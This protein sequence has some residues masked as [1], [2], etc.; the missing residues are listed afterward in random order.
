MAQIKCI[1]ITDLLVNPENYRFDPVASQKQAID[2]MINDQRENIFNIAKH[3]V[4]N[5]QNPNDMI[6]VAV[7]NHDK[8]KYIVLEGN[9]RVVA[10][11]ALINPDII[12]NKDNATLKSRF[13]KLHDENKDKLIQEVN[14]VVYDNPSEADKWIKL[15]HAGQQEGIGT[16]SW[17][18]QQIQRFEE[19]V[20]GKSSV[21][22]QTIKIL[23]TAPDVPLDIKDN[24]KSLKITNLDRLL[25]DPKVREFLGIEIN[26]GIIQSKVEEKE[27]IKGL[28]QVAKDLLDPSFSVKK[29]YTKEDREDYISKFPK[30]SIP[31]KNKEAEKTWQFN[32]NP[33][34]S[35]KSTKFKPNPLLRNKLI[36]T[37]CILLIN[38]PKV[39]AI[40]Y[41]LRKLDTTKYVNAVSVLFRVFVELSL[42]CFLEKNK[43]ISEPSAAKSKLRLDEKVNK[44][45]S[46][47]ETKS[48]ADAA[49]C[50][51]I[52]VAVKDTNGLLGIDT[53]HAY[54]HNNRFTPTSQ[55]LIATWDNIHTFMEKLWENIK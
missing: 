31:N 25:S 49:I 6:Q 38:N 26:H 21:A 39:N 13:K 19:K 11:K 32:G 42:D 55:N 7:S 2:L 52:K 51:G 50:K 28:S 27:V 46:Y 17:N 9:R 24:L 23:E 45:A 22:L 8:S 33:A 48:L 43:M 34:T 44:V 4:D 14:C 3:I 1:Q 37:S 5:G 20:E 35:K 29:I 36:P 40:Y 30:N 53:W 18:S 15:K 12:D 47:L 54:V 16:V 10:L 41:E